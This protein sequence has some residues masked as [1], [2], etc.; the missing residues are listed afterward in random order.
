MTESTG[1]LKTMLQALLKRFDETTLAGDKQR[2]AHI[3]F[4]TQVFADLA[5][6]RKQLDLTPTN[7]TELH[8]F[9]GL[10]GYYRK[11]ITHYGI[12]A[13][14]LT[15]LLT[16]K[17]FEWTEKAQVAFDLLKRAMV[18]ALPDFARPFAIET[19]ACDTGVGAVL[20]Q[21]GHPVAFLSKALG[22]RNQRL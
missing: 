20:A 17:G 11:F 14:P 10:T 1:E 16:K 8:G 13:K 9:L 22:V 6:I 21:E 19:D 7:A 3:A 15:S 18:T 12:I 2:E 5:H 4:N